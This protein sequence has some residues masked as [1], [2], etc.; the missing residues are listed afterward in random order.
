LAGGGGRGGVWDLFRGVEDGRVGRGG[1]AA[2]YVQ[3]GEPGG[4][5]VARGWDGFARRG[6]WGRGSVYEDSGGVGANG[7]AAGYFGELVVCC[8]DT[9][10]AAGCGG[11]VGFALSGFDDFV[12]GVDAS[13]EA[14]SAAR[15]GD[16]RGGGSRGDDYGLASEVSGQ[17][18]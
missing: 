12:G 7:R 17:A 5:F 14:Y 9:G 1:V 15:V 10:G 3:D 13:G 8:G 16:G 4:L 18:R 2:G 6:W 11:C